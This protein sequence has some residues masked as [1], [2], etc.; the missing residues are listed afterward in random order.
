M[1]LKKNISSRTSEEARDCYSTCSDDFG[2]CTYLEGLSY[3]K[4]EQLMRMFVYEMTQMRVFRAIN[5][6]R[7]H[8]KLRPT[9]RISRIK[10]KWMTKIVES[11]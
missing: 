7:T 9:M 1:I 5:A 4:I 2:Q 8:S 3:G 6:A 11:G 10:K